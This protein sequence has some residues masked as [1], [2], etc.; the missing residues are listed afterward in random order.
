VVIAVMA[1]FLSL[2]WSGSIAA[3]SSREAWCERPHSVSVPAGD[4][5]KVF[6]DLLQCRDGTGASGCVSGAITIT[7]NGSAA[8]EAMS[9]FVL[10]EY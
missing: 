7:A 1:V 10:F 5:A 6:F 8:S 9:V 3:A 4:G 2:W